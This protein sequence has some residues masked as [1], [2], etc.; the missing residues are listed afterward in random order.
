VVPF[1]Y[2]G[3]AIMSPSLFADAPSG[4]FSLTKMFDRANEQER[5]FGLRLDGVWMHVGTPDAVYAAEE[6]FLASV[7]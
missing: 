4:E 2:A 1:V 3:A 6:A 7:A 5:L